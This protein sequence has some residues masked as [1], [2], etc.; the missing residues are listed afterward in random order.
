VATAQFDL[1]TGSHN[2]M[3]TSSSGGLNLDNGILLVYEGATTA[4]EEEALPEGYAL[5]QNYPNPF[6][7]STTILYELGDSS[8]VT[9]TVYDL[10]GR[11]VATLVDGVQAAGAHAVQFDSARLASGTYFYRIDTAVGQ[12]VRKMMVVN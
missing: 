2:I 4:N 11:K 1:S 3:V 8:P 5:R 10:L 6:N 12:Q 7:A 9:L